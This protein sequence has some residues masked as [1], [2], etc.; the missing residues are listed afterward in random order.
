[1]ITDFSGVCGAEQTFALVCGAA[2]KYGVRH[3]VCFKRACDNSAATRQA[4]FL[5]YQH[6][7]PQHILEHVIDRLPGETRQKLDALQAEMHGKVEA[8]FMHIDNNKEAN[9][10]HAV[11]TCGKQLVRRV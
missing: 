10:K 6:A 7:A 9:R 1:M 8:I 3:K 11:S 5:T 2:S 4:L